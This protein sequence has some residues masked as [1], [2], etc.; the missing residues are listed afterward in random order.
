MIRQPDYFNRIKKKAS[1]R[2]DQ[3][4]EDPELAGPWH[5]LFRQIQSPRHVLSELLQNADDVN[6]SEAYVRI[7]EDKFIFEHNGNDF[8]ENNFNSLCNFAYSDK[9]S[10]HTIGFR[11][12]GFK[13]TF[14]LGDTV[15]LFTPTLSISFDKRRFTEPIWGNEEPSDAKTVIKVSIIRGKEELIKNLDEWIKDPISLLFF[16][17][18]R[19]LKINEHE[20]HWETEGSGPVDGSEWMKLTNDKEKTYLIVRSESEP[21]PENAV[22]EI[23]QERGIGIDEKIPPVRVEIVLNA[24]GRIY[25]V[26]PTE[27]KT[28]LPFAC[29]APFLQ[30]PSRTKI[31]EPTSSPTNEWLLKRAGSLAASTFLRWVENGS[32]S[33]EDRS[34]AYDLFPDVDRD[35][36]SL[37]GTCASA[38][39][40]AFEEKISE[41]PILLTNDGEI[42]LKGLSLI[43][44]ERLFGVWPEE[45][46]TKTFDINNRPSLSMFISKGNRGK[47]NNWNLVESITKEQVL[48][49]LNSKHLPKP[50][51][52]ERLLDLW[53]YIEPDIKP[54]YWNKQWVDVKIFPVVDNDVL[55]SAK[56]VTRLGEKK[57]LKSNEDWAFF[58]KYLKIVDHD[59]LQFIKDNS[60]PDREKEEKVIDKRINAAISILKKLE[61]ENPTNINHVIEMI[62]K[63][64]FKDSP[65][66]KDCVIF[67]QLTA[68]LDASVGDSFR[69]VTRDNYLRSKKDMIIFD[70]IGTVE[71]ILPKDYCDGHL[72]H[73]DYYEEPKA[74]SKEEW[75][76][77]I[78]SDKSDLLKFILPS[79]KNHQYWNRSQFENE[80]NQR[81]LKGPFHYTYNNRNYQIYDWDFDETI[82]SYWKKLAEKDDTIWKRI[83]LSLLNQ[84]ELRIKKIIEAD[85]CQLSRQY[86]RAYVSTNFVPE[87]IMRFR[88]LHCLPDNHNVIHKPNE[89]FRYTPST[90][91]FMDVEP[92]INS[93]LETDN[94]RPILDLLGVQST[95]A[96]ADKLL[97]CLRALSHSDTPPVHEVVKWYQRLDKL[98]NN[99]STEEIQKIKKSFQDE[100]ILFTEQNGWTNSFGAFI[101]SDEVEVPGSATVLQH[102]RELSLWQK[103]GVQSKPT[104]EMAIQWLKK[105]PSGKK[106]DK[107]DSERVKKLI[108]R[109][110]ERVWTDCGHWKNLEGSWVPVADL[111]YS[112]SMQSLVEW[113]NLFD[114]IKQKTADLRGISESVINS[115]PFSILTPLS[116]I[117]IRRP[118]DSSEPLSSED[119]IQWLNHFGME[120]TRID[121][122]DEN[123]KHRIRN[124]ANELSQTKW[125]ERK[126]LEVIP[127]IDGV[128]VG[129]PIK[130]EIA[131]F[132]SVLYSKPMSRPLLAKKIPEEIGKYFSTP[133]ITDA[134]NHCYERPI[135]YITEYL[136]ENFHLVP[137]S[138]DWSENE[139]YPESRPDQDF[140]QDTSSDIGITEDLMDKTHGPFQEPSDEIPEPAT[141][142]PSKPDETE[143]PPSLP[144]EPKPPK[145][146]TISLI[147][148]FAKSNGF[149]KDSEDRFFHANGSWI[150]KT[151]R[152]TFP[153]ERRNIDGELVNYYYTKEHCIEEK[154][155]E[156]RAEIWGLMENSPDKYSLILTDHEGNPKEYKGTELTSKK[157]RERLKIFPASYRLVM[158]D[159]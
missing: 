106:L 81:G 26:L 10:M 29:N 120:L 64:F 87:W 83:L 54:N 131:W 138:V 73:S 144:P 5:Q 53:T 55:Y 63:S 151:T 38:V 46:I 52:W 78:S 25:V 156:L 51:I 2:W 90:Q 37:N 85:A 56:E 134:L 20:I 6:A 67:A 108:S 62:S 39:E 116:T 125:E 128:P 104:V 48:S 94:N 60:D 30:D 33:I 27:I 133:D 82:W 152:D 12:I 57:L 137:I 98:V 148:R 132:N 126:N 149:R 44:P 21:F 15:Q 68:K 88:E 141:S 41:Q 145:P 154:P 150:S 42:V 140:D 18:I 3:L 34:K 1:K 157:E 47:L 119:K 159:E 43:Y 71:D 14:S 136:E 107:N 74:C 69:F 114:H 115:T 92:F 49:T 97:D 153:W 101:S 4:E 91:P 111:T 19:Y 58:S 75:N 36:G 72:L 95:P 102:I 129:T 130:T 121:V 96:N 22:K 100:N 80:L 11:G 99:T 7:E 110:P 28:P 76:K 13:S 112:I 84:Q 77:W 89:L 93:E 45:V 158:E 123:E 79:N 66:I 24:N 135:D 17:N 113:K 70:E 127:Y 16:K 61:L 105:L 146:P 8:T 124:L 23:K 142:D 109:H 139:K 59:W 118:D 50:E 9:R 122:N 143:I 65:S 35:D 103:I 40:I 31:I 117:I 86:T 147:E 155:L 32:M